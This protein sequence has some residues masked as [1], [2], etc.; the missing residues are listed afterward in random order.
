MKKRFFALF[1]AVLACGLPG[2]CGKSTV[3]EVDTPAATEQAA[4]Q[5]D[6]AEEI[7]TIEVSTPDESI[8]LTDEQLRPYVDITDFEDICAILESE[9]AVMEEDGETVARVNYNGYAAMIIH[10]EAHRVADGIGQIMISYTTDED[11]LETFIYSEDGVLLSECSTY[12]DGNF[13]ATNLGET[14]YYYRDNVNGIY[15]EYDL[16][17][18]MVAEAVFK[19]IDDKPYVLTGT[20]PFAHF[21]VTYAAE[22]S[23]LMTELVVDGPSRGHYKWNGLGTDNEDLI[24]Y[25]YHS[26]D[27]QTNSVQSGSIN[28]FMLPSPPNLLGV[29][30]HFTYLV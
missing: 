24:F 12:P 13:I 8:P 28:L 11:V 6:P 16:E 10:L 14:G 20:S 1:I 19:T 26:A 3:P 2:G 21:T 25:E 4:T 27:G 30:L 9:Y 18:N 5:P 23:T 15:K 29:M 22:D 17:G 7:P